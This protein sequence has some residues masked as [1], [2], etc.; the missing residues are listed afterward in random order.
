MVESEHNRPPAPG[1]FK[2]GFET[3][4]SPFTFRY[5]T[6]EMREIWSQENF[7]VTVRHIWIAVAEAQQEAG[8]VT[9][10]QVSDL[11]GHYDEIS[12][13]RI[14][15]LEKEKGHDVAAAIAEF[16]EVAPVG[17]EI[18]HQGLTSEDVLSNAEIIQIHESLGLVRTKLVA[19]LGVFGKQIDRYKDLVCMG[20]THLQ[21]AEPTTMGY[22]FA[23]YAQDLLVDLKLL[24]AVKPLIK[25][26]GIKGAVGTSASFAEILKGTGMSIEEHERKVMERFG[27]EAASISDQTYPR[28]F[29]FLTESIL[30]SVGQSLHRFALD[31]QILQSSSI[32]EVSEPRRKGQ[33]SSSAMPHKHNPVNAENIDSLTEMLPGKAFSAWMTSAYVTLE[34]TLRDSAGKRSWLPESFLIV[35][36]ALRRTER[37]VQG[38]VVHEHSVETNLKFFAPFCVTEIILAE[39]TKAGMDRK[40]A[41]ELLVEHA[42]TAVEAKRRGLPNPMRR[43]LL[44]DK[45]VT[46]LLSRKSVKQAFEEIFTHVGNAPQKCVDFLKNELHPAIGKKGIT[47]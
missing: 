28:K 26:K 36:E 23:R 25:G 33:I 27:I 14:F 4:L 15:Q 1:S 16:S 44:A 42:E 32:D 39:L 43:L 38:L 22:R 29:L 10:E 37:V 45:R 13:E 24:D 17:G 12:V 2:A 11:M 21:A 7:W 5:G 41:H 34:R 18:L 46:S 19:V 40:E 8:L 6:G 31:L 30:S 9:K 35:D 47:I 20:Y 3:Y